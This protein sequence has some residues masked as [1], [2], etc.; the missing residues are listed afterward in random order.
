MAQWYSAGLRA[1]WSGVLVSARAGNSSLHHR[2]QTGSGAHPAPYPMG[3]RSSFPGGK[4]AGAWSCP[5][6]S[7]KECVELYLHSPNTP[8]WRGAQLKKKHRDNFNLLYLCHKRKAVPVTRASASLL[9]RAVFPFHKHSDY[10]VILTGRYVAG[11]Q[12]PFECDGSNGLYCWEVKPLYR[13]SIKTQQQKRKLPFW[14][15][16]P[17]RSAF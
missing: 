16:H 4:A 6:T 17:K 10:C 3:T 11:I 9:G 13:A 8:S 7:I 14:E 12:C 5:L 15:N 1:E 2:I